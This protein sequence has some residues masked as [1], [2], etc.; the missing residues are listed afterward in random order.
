MLFEDQRKIFILAP[1]VPEVFQPGGGF[2]SSC[3][4]THCDDPGKALAMLAEIRPDIAFV[5][6]GVEDSPA[7]ELYQII[8]GMFEGYQ[9]PVI[10]FG[11][12][13]HDVM[14][15]KVLE[16]GALSYFQLPLRMEVIKGCLLSW[17]R[18]ADRLR[19]T[20]RR[21]QEK[22][23]LLMMVTHDL[24]NPLGRATFASGVLAEMPT[25]KRDAYT[26]QLIQQVVYANEEISRL[27]KMLLSLSEMESEACLD[28][29][30]VELKALIER[31]VQNYQ[32]LAR[33]KGVSVAPEF[34]DTML[35]VEADPVWL[36]HAIGNLLSNAIKFTPDGGLVSVRLMESDIGVV[37]Q[38]RDTGI[39][40]RKTD[41]PH[42]FE[43]FYRSRRKEIR[44]AEGS[45]L[46][47]A[48]VK[49]AVSRHGG[50]VLVD[51]REGE[52][53]T[54]SIVLPPRLRCETPAFSAEAVS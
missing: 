39:G 48:I 35:L 29:S 46:G 4:V 1:E 34:P 27:V 15:S 50:Q 9:V 23:D 53:S 47:L 33:L 52:G 43:K 21:L 40:I 41:L 20:H 36:E 45:G 10:C 19:S 42:I 37:V 44:E 31:I 18:I 8:R 25:L 17:M 26:H 32:F 12:A 54:F 6:L 28:L 24:K 51:S 5:A 22:D 14:I 13:S 49:T 11:H 16:V 2:C 38:V 3:E 30:V 7:F